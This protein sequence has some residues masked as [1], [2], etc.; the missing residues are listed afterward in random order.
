MINVSMRY[1]GRRK[2]QTASSSGGGGVTYSRLWTNSSPSSS[3]SSL[4]ANLSSAATDYTMLRIVWARSTSLGVTG[5]NWEEHPTDCIAILYDMRTASAMVGGSSVGL[6][7]GA[8]TYSSY[9]YA[10][11]GYFTSNAYTAITFGTCGRQNGSGTSNGLLI[12]V[13]IDS[14]TIT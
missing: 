12:P 4:T 14:V 11:R 8:S 9:A 5:D 13:C 2:Q 3:F 6:F 10:R 7:F 1:G